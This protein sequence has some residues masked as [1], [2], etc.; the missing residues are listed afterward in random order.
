MAGTHLAPVPGQ[1]PRVK[2]GKRGQPV[3]TPQ[4]IERYKEAVK[5]FT[6]RWVVS[7]LKLSGK[8]VKNGQV[9]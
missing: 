5:D 7:I 8:L 1:K 3:A 9:S 4:E 2:P 6:E